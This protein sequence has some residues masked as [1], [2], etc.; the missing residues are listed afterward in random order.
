[1]RAKVSPSSR[2]RHPR[3]IIS[4]VCLLFLFIRNIVGQRRKFR[5]DEIHFDE[6][7]KKSKSNYDDRD[8]GRRQLMIFTFDDRIDEGADNTSR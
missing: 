2:M 1:M 5:I 4:F 7:T 8:D 6:P 3:H